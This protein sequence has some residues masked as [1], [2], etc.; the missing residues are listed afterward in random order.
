MIFRKG[1]S[2][3]FRLVVSQIPLS[4]LATAVSDDVATLKSAAKKVLSKLS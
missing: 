3:S 2:L 1:E 4:S